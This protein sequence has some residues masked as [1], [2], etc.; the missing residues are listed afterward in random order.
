LP[1]LPGWLKVLKI[2]DSSS[3]CLMISVHLRTGCYGYFLYL[4]KNNEENNCNKIVIIDN[5]L[6]VSS[7]YICSECTTG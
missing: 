7:K 5:N 1:E 6:F 4:E 2:K 3:A